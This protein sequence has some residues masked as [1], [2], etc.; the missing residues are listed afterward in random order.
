MNARVD[1]NPTSEATALDWAR[2]LL[3][4]LALAGTLYVNYLSNALPING[5]TPADISDSFPSLVTPAGYVFSI[6]G[7]IYLGLIVYAV[8]QALPA[9]RTDPLQRVVGWLFIATC[10]FNGSWIFAF[11]YA[12]YGLSLLLMLGLLLT[13]IKIY[14]RIGTGQRPP[15][16]PSETWALRLPFS[17]YLGWITIATIA[18]VTI[19]LLDAGWGG[20]GLPD[21]AWAVLVLIVGAGINAAIARRH[22]DAAYIGVFVWAYAGI[23]A[24]HSDVMPVVLT[25]GLMVP[26]VVLALITAPGREPAAA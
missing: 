4:I 13:L 16:E 17:L 10:L 22:R 1:S 12:R 19:V 7:L 3:V 2:Q 8:W 18:N 23:I 15:A 21:E 11:H 24:K 9:R 25:A 26:V 14:L 6:W 5:R 20:W